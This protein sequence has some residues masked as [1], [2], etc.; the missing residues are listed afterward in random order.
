MLRPSSTARFA[1]A[2]LFAAFV[3]SFG[4]LSLTGSDS[5]RDSTPEPGSEWPVL[6]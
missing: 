6:A 1:L 2:A 5:G 3:V 4:V